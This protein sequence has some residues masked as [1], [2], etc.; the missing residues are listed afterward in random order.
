MCSFTSM[1]YQQEMWYLWSKSKTAYSILSSYKMLEFFCQRERVF[2]N[3]VCLCR[4]LKNVMILR[5][6]FFSIANAF[7]YY[8]PLD[9]DCSCNWKLQRISDYS[10]MK[11]I[12]FFLQ[13]FHMSLLS[14]FKELL[15]FNH[16]QRYC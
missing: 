2:F 1:H 12:F 13:C 8:Y 14:H 6:Y 15:R 3:E 5:G 7:N 16:Y 11:Y 10:A 4:A 9:Q